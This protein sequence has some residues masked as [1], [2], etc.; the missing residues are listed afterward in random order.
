L[1]FARL[2]TVAWVAAFLVLGVGVGAGLFRAAPAAPA[3]ARAAPADEP[4]S[5]HDRLQGTWLVVEIFEGEKKKEARGQTLTISGNEA[6][7]Q[8]D[9]PGSKGET[10]VYKLDPGQDPK[11]IDLVKKTTGFGRTHGIYRLDGDKLTLAVGDKERR[12]TGFEAAAGVSVLVL[13]RK[14]TGKP[15]KETAPSDEV[16]FELAELRGKVTKLEAR[17]EALTRLLEQAEKGT[18]CALKAV[19]VEK[20]TVSVVLRGTTLAL[21]RVAVAADVKFTLDGKECRID[22][23]KPGLRASVEWIVSGDRTLVAAVHASSGDE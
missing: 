3:G 2:K 16:L 20:N 23:L 5:D 4:R 6:H 13:K 10:Y 22:E 7:F 17:G 9:E 14:A 18:P 11:W 8:S 1:L 19:D 15:K 21:E 12:P